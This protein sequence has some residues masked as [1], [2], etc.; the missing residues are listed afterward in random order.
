MKCCLPAWTHLWLLTIGNYILTDMSLLEKRSNINCSYNRRYRNNIVS[1]GTMLHAGRLL[2][3]FPMSL[4]FSIDLILLATQWPLGQL[5]PYEKWVSEIF[6]E[7]KGGQRM[8]LKTLPPSVSQMFR[9]CV[10]LNISQH[11]GPPWP[12]T[13]IALSFTVIFSGTNTDQWLHSICA[14]FSSKLPFTKKM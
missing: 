7:V 4:G 11:C 12:L 3:R 13:K 10:S 5:R 6:L 14:L 8:R 9:N 1:S 2:V